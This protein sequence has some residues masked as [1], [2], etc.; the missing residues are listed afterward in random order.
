MLANDRVHRPLCRSLERREGFA[1]MV[2]FDTHTQPFTEAPY[3]A[4]GLAPLIVLAVNRSARRRWRWF[5]GLAVLISGLAA[6]IPAWDRNRLRAL[7]DV[8]VA[9]GPLRGVWRETSVA[10]DFPKS[11]LAYKRWTTEG[12]WVGDE[13]FRYVMG[14]GLSS[15]AFTNGRQIDLKPYE[16]QTVEIRWFVD[17]ASQNERRILRLA[18]V[19]M[20]AAPPIATPAA[21]IDPG[22]FEQVWRRFA[23]AAAEGDQPAVRGMTKLPF[24]LGGNDVAADQFD[25]LW[26]G[27]FTPST[28]DCL[29]KA[30]PVADQ[31]LMEAFC[32]G[33]I[34][35]FAKIDGVWKF[36]EIGAD[37]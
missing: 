24:M 9:T 19:N 4:L 8:Q 2:L 10:R 16:G 25:T 29:A 7:R 12:F 35:I 30:K 17:P 32:N 31:Q 26:A 33:T 36:T 23:K 21:R 20:G 6:G 22:N 15:A 37:D 3:A 5:L 11:S 14:R 1:L 28:R 13:G 34:F 18:V 27:L